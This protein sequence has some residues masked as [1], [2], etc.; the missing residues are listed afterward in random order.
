MPCHRLTLNFYFFSN[1]L[2]IPLKSL[3]PGVKL[4]KKYTIHYDLYTTMNFTK[5]QFCRFVLTVCTSLEIPFPGM[6]GVT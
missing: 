3:I 1:M 4:E 6:A 2:F 5:C